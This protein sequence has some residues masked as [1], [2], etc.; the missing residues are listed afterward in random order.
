MQAGGLPGGFDAGIHGALE[1]FGIAKRWRRATYYDLNETE[2]ESLA[3][4]FQDHRLL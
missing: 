3:G 1:L 4:F 2:M